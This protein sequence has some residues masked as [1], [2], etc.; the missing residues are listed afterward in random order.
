MICDGKLAGVVSWGYG[1]ARRLFPGVYTDV[2]KL[3]PFVLNAV[4]S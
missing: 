2:S 1:C 4:N 3:K